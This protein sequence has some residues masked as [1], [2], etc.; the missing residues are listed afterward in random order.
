MFTSASSSAKSIGSLATSIFGNIETD[1]SLFTTS[2]EYTKVIEKR[3]LMNQ[4][5]LNANEK[6]ARKLA[7]EPLNK[8]KEEIVTDRRRY[9]ESKDTKKLISSISV[10]VLKLE[11]DEEINHGI[12][13]SFSR[14]CRSIMNDSGVLILNCDSDISLIPSEIMSAMET[15]ALNIISMICKKLTEKGIVYHA[16]EVAAKQSFQSCSA[17]NYLQQEQQHSFK[18]DEVAS[19]C[20]GRLDIRH[21]MSKEPFNHKE[22]VDNEIMMSAV[23]SILGADAVLVYAGIVVSFPSSSDQPWHQD[24]QMLFPENELADDFHLPA[25]ALNVFIPLT[26]ISEEIGP[27]EF[28]VGS[29]VMQASKASMQHIAANELSK[30]KVIGPLLKKGDVLIYD[31]RTCHRGT[32]NLSMKE[33]RTM[34][35]LMYARPWF[36]EHLNFGKNKL[37]DY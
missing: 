28:C 4:E 7:F 26:D 23:R 37:F 35:Y 9:S 8:S 24:G 16:K 14:Q 25:Y 32:Q 18:F 29:H 19:R 30:A 21:N 22:I 1:N 2:D 6:I 3:K 13:K 36:R 27:T 10:P 31:Y 5:A 33:T 20:L 17:D 15:E 12:L 11:S 34:L